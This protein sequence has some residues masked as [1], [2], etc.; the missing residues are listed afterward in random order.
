MRMKFIGM[1]YILGRSPS[2]V[3]SRVQVIFEIAPPGN[4]DAFGVYLKG[5]AR[6]QG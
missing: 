5:L 2:L 1:F 4:P 6:R 3:A